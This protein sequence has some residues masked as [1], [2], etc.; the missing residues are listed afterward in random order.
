M[1]GFIPRLERE[2]HRN[3]VVGI[4]CGRLLPFELLMSGTREAE[5]AL[6]VH[7][8]GR[9]RPAGSPPWPSAIDLQRSEMVFSAKYCTANTDTK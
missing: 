6:C 5:G 9:E 4:A 1:Y 7:T 8:A 2:C 3:C